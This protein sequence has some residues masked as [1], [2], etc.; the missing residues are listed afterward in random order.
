MLGPPRGDRDIE[1]ARNRVKAA[2]EAVDRMLT[3]DTFGAQQRL[4]ADLQQPFW[5]LL[6]GKRHTIKTLH[7][8]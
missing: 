4:S 3:L 8:A 7:I 6:K 5:N 2:G 1:A